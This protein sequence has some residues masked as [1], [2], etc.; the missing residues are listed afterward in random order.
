MKAEYSTSRQA[1]DKLIIDQAQRQ[2]QT[3]FDEIKNGTRNYR[4]IASLDA[5]IAQAY[6]G[7]CI[8]ELLQ[9]AHDALTTAPSGDP[10]RVSFVLN[11]SSRP[12][13]L[14]GNSGSPFHPDNFAG[15][16]Q[17]GQSPKDPNQSV[18]N[19]GL[20]FRS[21]LE[22]STSPE[23]WSTAPLGSQTSFVF[24]FDPA[25]SDRVA[26]AVQELEEEG[27]DARSPFNAACPL[28]D[29]SE[30]Q[31]TQ[32]RDRVADAPLDCAREASEFLS[33]YLIPL[34]IQGMPPEVKHLLRQ[35]HVTVILLP[36]DGGGSGTSD[37]AVQSVKEQ[38]GSLDAQAT[39][40]LGQAEELSIDIDGEHRVLKRMV[41]S[42]IGFSTRPRSWRQRLLVG[43]SGPA[44]DHHTTR[45]FQVWTRTI[46][47]E[48][49]PEQAGRIRAVVRN[50]PN[51]WPEVSGVVVGVAVEEA[52]FARSGAVR[53]LSADSDAD[54]DRG[55]HQCAVL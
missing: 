33:P 15:L 22:V 7:R 40:F 26:A 23:I 39:V 31:F 54:G 10:R 14:I 6:R 46:G 30:E 41:E 5:Q 21:V 11:S 53:R 36:L 20:G 29:W 45:E 3:F 25:V 12:V 24:R 13:L 49:D 43:Q 42:E 27:L 16:C 44:P 17:L 1:G 55:A 2:V 28:L 50:L 9:N 32:Y 34:C 19:K 4:T 37:K 47:G 48:D 52:P 35:G 51:R 8:L 38:L 18:G